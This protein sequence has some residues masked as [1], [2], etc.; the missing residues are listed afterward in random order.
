MNVGHTDVKALGLHRGVLIWMLSAAACGVEGV[1]ALESD[2][3]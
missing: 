2:L 3:V 1:R